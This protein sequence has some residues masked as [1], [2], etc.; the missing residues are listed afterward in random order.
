MPPYY[1]RK[2]RQPWRQRNY[3]R[4]RRPRRW[5]IR[6][7]IRRRWRR[8]H[9]VRKKRL[10]N[11]RKK[12]TRL[13]LK[14]WQPK[15]IKKCSIKGILPAFICGKSRIANNYVLFSESIVPVGEPGGGAW[16]ILQ[17]NLRAL[18]DQFIK[19]KNWWTTSNQGLPLTR[20]LGMKITFY[21]TQ[22]VDYIVVPQLCPPFSVTRDNYLNIHPVRMLMNRHKIIIPQ[23]QKGK[24]NYIKKWFR[25]PDLMQNKWYFQQDLVN[26]PFIVLHITAASLDQYSIPENQISTN[27]TLWSL[28]T[29]FFRNNQ[30]TDYGDEGYIPKTFGTQNYYLYTEGNGT[31]EPKKFSQMIPLKNTTTYSDGTKATK[32]TE[33]KNKQTW[34][35]PFT[36]NHSSPDVPIYYN[37]TTPSED[38]YTQEHV[39]TPLH[40]LYFQCRYNPEKDTGIGNKVFFKSNK[41]KQGEIDT[42]PDKDEIVITDFPLWLIFYSWISWIQKSK[43]IQHIM[44]D[45]YFIV[46][47]PFIEP[48]RKSYLFLDSYFVQPISN[49]L[50]VTEKLHW[51]PQTAYQT[52]VIFSFAQTGPAAPKVDRSQS[53]QAQF[54]YNVKLKWGGCPA[55]MELITDPSLQ[56]KFPIPNTIF[57]T[58]EIQNPETNKRTL[59]YDFDERHDGLTDRATK[60]IKREQ[61]FETSFTG[62]LPTDPNIRIETQE[63]TSSSEEESE[64]SLQE[65]L[66][67]LK[68]KNKQ[69]RNKLLRLTSY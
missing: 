19:Y 18:Y 60:R 5:R 25:P 64:T 1:F 3:R 6:S 17:I 44:N 30:F 26:I 20:Y 34:G 8:R 11:R 21:K 48:K 50:T 41:L 16:S 35:N 59:L 63:T 27:I 9:W 45:Y 55:P 15:K 12:L 22:Y 58:L 31:T 39:F 23:R 65:E 57:K 7:L 32:F 43:P 28:N 37:N 49:R 56:D 46:I 10:F 38:N 67:L 42:I 62:Q 53:I 66:K 68:R 33:W 40:E 14:E 61:I 29:D 4:F 52:D 51:Y 2:R 24:K 54:K 69:L 47:T 36:Q 13:T